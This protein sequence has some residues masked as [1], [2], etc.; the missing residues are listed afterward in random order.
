MLTIAIVSQKGMGR[1]GQIP[2]GLCSV[3]RGGSNSFTLPKLNIGGVYCKTISNRC[4][5]R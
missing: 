2:R 4:I 3:D 1:E 5:V